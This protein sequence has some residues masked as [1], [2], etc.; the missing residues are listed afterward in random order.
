MMATSTRAVREAAV[1]AAREQGYAGLKSEQ[2]KVVETFVKGRDVFAVL[3]TGY[4]KSL[5][6]GCL[7]IV[8]DKLLGTG[9]QEENTVLLW[10][11]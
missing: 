9:L 7:P 5:C 3:P 1:S 6:Y 4:G 8:F 2:L 11:L 10:W